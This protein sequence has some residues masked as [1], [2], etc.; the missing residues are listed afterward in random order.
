M[1]VVCKKK[2]F[3]LGKEI[4]YRVYNFLSKIDVNERMLVVD[5]GGCDLLCGNFFFVKFYFK[6]VS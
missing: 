4:I 5:R 6:N 3:C 2:D 1:I